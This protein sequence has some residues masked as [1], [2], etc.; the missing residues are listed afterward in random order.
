MTQP[1]AKIIEDSVSQWGKRLTTMEVTMH[2]FILAEMNTHRAFSRNSASSRAIPVHKIIDRVSSDPAYPIYWGAEQKGMQSGEGL[3]DEVL[4]ECREE[5]EYMKTTSLQS[6]VRLAG[7]GLHKSLTNRILEPFMWHTA[8]ISAT[9]WDNFFHQR[10]SPAAQPEMKA[11]ADAMQLAYYTST[12]KNLPYGSWHTPYVSEQEKEYIRDMFLSGKYSN[13]PEWHNSSPTHYILG[14]SVA[15][16]ARVSYLTHDG[17][18]DVEEDYKLFLRL[19]DSG[20]WSPFEHVATP[21]S[22]AFD[23]GNFIG[24]KQYRKNF[25]DENITQFVS[26]LPELAHIREQIWRDKTDECGQ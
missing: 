5:W 4:K 17:K 23:T 18:R 9:E 21:T 2:R 14:V 8:I 25:R 3:S 16:C 20:H 10:C 7:A 22:V 6:A 19:K 12:P 1:S 15:R 11:V 13:D 24:W 26:N